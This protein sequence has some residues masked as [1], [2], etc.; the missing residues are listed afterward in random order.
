MRR[1][2]TFRAPNSSLRESVV[3]LAC[4]LFLQLN[5]TPAVGKPRQG[6]NN[7]V[8]VYTIVPS[9]RRQF[10]LDSFPQS[11]QS[12]LLV[13]K[14]ALSLQDIEYKWKAYTEQSKLFCLYQSLRA[15]LPPDKSQSARSLGKMI[16]NKVYLALPSNRISQNNRSVQP[17]SS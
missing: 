12:F 15:C 1:A 14:I 10:P 16:Q 17:R 3:R 6:V 9:S 5:S 8:L 7:S 4:N 11:L 2:T 13:A